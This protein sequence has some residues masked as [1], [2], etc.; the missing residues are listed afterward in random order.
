MSDDTDITPPDIMS[1]GADTPSD[2]TSE[3]RDR[4]RL[5]EWLT[6]IKRGVQE[7]ARPIVRGK[8]ALEQLCRSDAIEDLEKVVTQTDRLRDADLE[9]IDLEEERMQ[10]VGRLD[11]YIKRRQRELRM[12]FAKALDREARR[13][14]VTTETIS[15]SPLVIRVPPFVVSTDFDREQATLTYAKEQLEEVGLGPDEILDARDKWVDW[16]RGES[17]DSE[18]FV[19][20]LQ[21]AYELALEARGQTEGD[22]VDIVDLRAPLGLLAG[23]VEDWRRQGDETPETYPRWLL[24][25]QLKHLRRDNMLE[26]DGKR[27][28][29]G[30]ATGG[31]T[32]D[33]DNVLFIRSGREGGQYYL[34]IRV[35]EA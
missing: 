5:V 17:V 23:D 20:W 7:K 8:K 2:S 25:Y 6:E 30:T 22:R 1:D 13:R 29:L 4:D 19:R 35:T 24:S 33:K 26:Y 27:I 18:S 16:I 3:A 21:R 14:E 9:E 15:E 11:A 34:S 28:D 32:D 12:R 10:A 31:S